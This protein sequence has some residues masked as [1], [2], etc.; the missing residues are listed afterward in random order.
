MRMTRAER[1][2][3]F[4]NLKYA[5]NLDRIWDFIAELMVDLNAADSDLAQMQKRIDMPRPL[6]PACAECFEK[7]GSRECLGH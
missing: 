2:H 6:P 5:S 3:K 4:R 1:E 7:E